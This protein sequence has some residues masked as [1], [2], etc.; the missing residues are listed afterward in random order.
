MRSI[1]E[2]MD[3]EMARIFVHIEKD[4]Q[5]AIDCSK[6]LR[7]RPVAIPEVRRRIENVVS[8]RKVQ[9]LAA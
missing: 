9:K 1:Y 8:S 4:Y 3:H 2:R 5:A 6:F 7:E